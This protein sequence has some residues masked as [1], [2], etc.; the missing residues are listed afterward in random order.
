MSNP[1]KPKWRWRILRWGLISLAVLVTLVA[2]LITEENWRGKRDW[3]AYKMAAEARGEWFAWS[4]HAIT[5]VPDDQNFAKAPIFASISSP[6]KGKTNSPPAE[7]PLIL[8]LY[9]G[10]PS[11]DPGGHGD[12]TRAR[13]TRL[14]NWQNYYRHPAPQFAGVFPI[15]AQPQS[16]GADVLLALSKYDAAVGG[17]RE[18]CQRPFVQFGLTNVIENN[19]F[20][21]MLNYL[22]VFKRFTQVLNLRAI[23]ELADNQPDKGLADIQ[24]MLK[25]DDKLGSQPLLIVQLVG[26]A[27]NAYTLQPIYEG[28]GQH[29]WKDAQ[30]ED[31]ESA[32][33]E[34]DFLAD[35]QTAMAGE[36]AFAI[37]TEENR[38]ITREYQTVVDESPG[39]STTN[40]VSMR[41]VPSA[42][43]Y[44]NELKLARL[45][46]EVALPLVDVT[47]R[48]V[49]PAVVRQVTDNVNRQLKH[50]S[51]YK[52]EGLMTIRPIINCA[53]KFAIAQSNMDLAR[54]ACALERYRLAHGGYPESLDA[55]APQYIDKL[56]H[57]IIN[58]QPLHYRRMEGGN[59][60][61]YSVGWNEK[62]DGG[63]VALSKNGVMDREKG[64]W[65]WDSAAK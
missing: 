48:M 13:L 1:P 32:L 2:A 26:M 20:S 38:R 7:D 61:L 34:R 49:S 54:V 10:D 51:P 17:L 5:N 58:G 64:D 11:A 6:Q 53:K 18:A 37:E 30:L 63:E 16:P 29:R 33:A 65:V 31:L 60:V 36:R 50:F 3:E 56:P 45:V 22:A 42:I 44:R 24:L 57:D 46:D 47:N 19:G 4:A 14:E 40:T 35:Y 9:Y 62:D 55:L 52:I 41:F 28:L 39:K 8:N 25:L 27:I 59:F 12:W 21:Q 15:A 43:F 23:A